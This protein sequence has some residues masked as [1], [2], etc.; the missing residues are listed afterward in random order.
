MVA[1]K[2]L[3]YRDRAVE[4]SRQSRIPRVWV[5]DSIQK[6]GRGIAQLDRVGGRIVSQGVHDDSGGMGL[7][8]GIP[9]LIKVIPGDGAV[10]PAI[11]RFGCRMRMMRLFKS[12]TPATLKTTTRGPVALI[13]ALSEP[14]PEAPRCVTVI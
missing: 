7:E 2:T 1:G 4:H 14:G 6:T 9:P 13:A 8:V 5:A 12:M 10:S 11:V 3:A